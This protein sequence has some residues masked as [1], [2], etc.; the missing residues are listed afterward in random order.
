MKNKFPILFILLTIAALP[1]AAQLKVA[2][3]IVP[4]SPADTYPTHFDSLGSGGFVTVANI[5]NRNALVLARRKVGMMVYVVSEDKVYQLKGGKED[6]KWTELTIAT[7]SSSGGGVSWR[8]TVSTVSALSTLSPTATINTIARVT[9]DNKTYLYTGPTQG[10]Q[11][12][13]ENRSITW[14]GTFTTASATTLSP[15]IYDAYFI[16]DTRKSL[17]WDGTSWETLAEGFRWAGTF[18]TW[19][20]VSIRQNPMM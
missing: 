18:G 20:D 17:I 19:S 8:G 9:E 16:S 2:F 15:T 13:A 12:L 11:V 6:D 1:L 10:W 5:T 7:G 14:R 3:P 4:N